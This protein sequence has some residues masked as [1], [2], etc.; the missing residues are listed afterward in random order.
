MTKIPAKRS[1]AVDVT[2]VLSVGILGP[3]LIAAM[4]KWWG[5][6]CCART[7]FRNTTRMKCRK[8]LHMRNVAMGSLGPNS[9]EGADSQEGSEI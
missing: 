6:G 5:R 2:D 1:A 4:R 3:E 7:F 9:W 8:S